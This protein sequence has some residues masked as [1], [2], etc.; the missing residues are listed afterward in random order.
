MDH[1]ARTASKASGTK[2]LFAGIAAVGL[3]A[4]AYGVYATTL[5]VT[6]SAGTNFQAGTTTSINVTGAC[7]PNGMQVNETWSTVTLN[8]GTGYTAT[9]RE[10][11]TISG[12][13]DACNGRT[14]TLAV[15]STAGNGS[16]TSQFVPISTSANVSTAQGSVDARSVTIAVPAGY[17]NG[18]YTGG[19]PSGENIDRSAVTDTQA[20]SIKIS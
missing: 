2:K 19:V 5:T 18:T 8:D 3:A 17:N 12:I 9:S 11:W 13:A 4:G 14:L 10:S 15:K 20:Y 16:S 7:D 1:G 6:G